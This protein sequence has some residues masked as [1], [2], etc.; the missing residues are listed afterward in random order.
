MRK[1][2]LEPECR[3]GCSLS[4]GSHELSPLTDKILSSLSGRNHRVIN[5]GGTAYITPFTDE[6]SVKGISYF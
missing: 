2:A 6:M 5:E 1:V 4:V 3:M